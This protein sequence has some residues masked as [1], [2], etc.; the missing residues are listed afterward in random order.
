MFISE[1]EFKQLPRKQIKEGVYRSTVFTQNLMMAIIDFTNGP[2]DEPE[3][4]HS[5]P[6]EQI[7]YVAKG[8]IIFYCEGRPEIHLREGDVYAAPSGKKHTVKLLTEQVRLIDSFT[9]I[10]ED[11][12]K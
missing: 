9:P 8:E 4:Y 1:S 6:H 10:R 7:A 2:W 5:H 12:L 3:P 11:F